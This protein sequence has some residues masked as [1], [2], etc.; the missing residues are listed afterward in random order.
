MLCTLKKSF[1]ACYFRQFS[2]NIK[3]TNTSFVSP[4]LQPLK[5]KTIN[6]YV[7]FDTLYKTRT[8]SLHC[9]VVRESVDLLLSQL[10]SAQNLSVSGGC[11][12]IGEI[13][14]CSA[15]PMDDS[16]K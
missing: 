3:K 5:Y 2:T 6:N 9:C 4:G 15:L 12:A 7:L 10:D 11:V 13:G 8:K 1:M 14:R 16:G